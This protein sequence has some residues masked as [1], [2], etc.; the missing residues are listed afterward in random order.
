MTDF[1]EKFYEIQ[2]MAAVEGLTVEEFSET[3]A[4]REMAGEYYFEISRATGSPCA[5]QELERRFDDLMEIDPA[6]AIGGQGDEER[7][8]YDILT[9]KAKELMADGTVS[10]FTEAVEL[11]SKRLPDVANRHVEWMRSGQ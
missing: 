5:M 4:G 2:N 10:S 11:A 1:E 6:A 7:A 8:P 3:P 9:D